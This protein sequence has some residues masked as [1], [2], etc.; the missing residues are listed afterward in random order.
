[1]P[2]E[3]D[4]RLRELKFTLSRIFR[5]PAAIIGFSLM[6]V[7]VFIASAAPLLAPPY[8]PQNPYLMP[9]DGFNPTP[10]APS[11]QS[12]HFTTKRL[13]NIKR[14]KEYTFPPELYTRLKEDFKDKRF[15][16]EGEM[17]TALQ[18]DNR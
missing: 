6:A 1:M 11:G 15:L 17:V 5:N 3:Q 10:K 16:D 4:P 12:Y 14:D 18:V 7:F 8:D 9:H 2:K 13:L